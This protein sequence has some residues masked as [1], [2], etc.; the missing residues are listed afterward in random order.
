MTVIYITRHGQ[1]LW[2][3]DKR[4]QGSGNSKLTELGI[5]Q[6]KSL[7]ERLRNIEI[8]VIYSSPLERAYETAKILRGN[9]EIEIVT[10]NGIREISFG[11]Y[12]GNTET[13]LLKIGKGL[14]I[15]KI[16]DGEMKIK[17]PGGESLE[18]LYERTRISLNNILEKEKDKK[19]LVVSH[20]MTIKAIMNYFSKDDEYFSE[21]MGQAT[22]TKIIVNEEG[23]NIEFLNDSSHIKS[24]NENSGW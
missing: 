5:N 8:D 7:E 12:E 19:I 17:S 23:F 10:D 11:E 6:A 20:G 14:E 15:K 24:S 16:F 22:L 9:K 3:I 21:I 2:N 18:E 4:L 1:T 13:E